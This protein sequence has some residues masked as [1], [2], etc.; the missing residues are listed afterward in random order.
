MTR[1]EVVGLLAFLAEC[2]PL[3]PAP[4]DPA[5]RASVWYSM[6]EEWDGKQ[7]MAAAREVAMSDTYY[8][9]IARLVEELAPTG[10]A[11]LRQFQRR[12]ARHK[13]LGA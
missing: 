8:P 4:P 6:L 9:S 13:A 2:Y 1:R 11:K 10:Y 5:V 12:E 3:A 7:V